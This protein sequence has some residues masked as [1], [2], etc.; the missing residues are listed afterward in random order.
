MHDFPISE[1]EIFEEFLRS[2]DE[3]DVAI[4]MKMLKNCGACAGKLD[5]SVGEACRLKND[6]PSSNRVLPVE[7]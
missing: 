5:E 7:S 2:L 4:A 3:S 1:I 6:P